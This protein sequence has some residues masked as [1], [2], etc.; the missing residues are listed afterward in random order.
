MVKSPI[1]KSAFKDR[2]STYVIALVISMDK[3][4]ATRKGIL[5]H[6]E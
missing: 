6:I 1:Q 2:C 5:A 4:H 3:T